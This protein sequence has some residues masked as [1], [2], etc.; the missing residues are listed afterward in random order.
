[1]PL[2]SNSIFIT[3]L[4][5]R[6]ILIR[7]TAFD[8]D[9]CIYFVSK[10]DGSNMVK[11]GFTC[12]CSKQILANGGQEMLDELYKGMRIGC[13]DRNIVD[14]QI[15][16]SEWLPDFDITLGIDCSKLPKT[17]KIKKDMDEE[18]ANKVRAQNEEC[19][20]ER[21]RIADD[22]CMKFSCFKKDFL[23]APIRRALKQLTVATGVPSAACE[24][25]YR[26]DEKYWV[27]SAK[28]EVTVSFALQFDN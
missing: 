28:G 20:K 22:I 11:F 15:A 16:A 21:D 18:E 17:Q 24:L 7:E 1:M 4:T 14:Y 5:H 26:A 12:N 13:G 2:P 9:N 8:Y 23:G 10:E 6:D 3:Q 25:P 19:R 27:V